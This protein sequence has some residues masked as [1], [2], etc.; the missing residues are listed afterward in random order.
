M[1]VWKSSG[2]WIIEYSSALTDQH[3]IGTGN[4]RTVIEYT[5]RK[6]WR[7]FRLVISIYNTSLDNVSEENYRQDFPPAEIHILGNL[8]ILTL[9]PMGSGYPLFPMGEGHMAPLV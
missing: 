2:Q 5:V 9:F 7:A 8:P 1:N 6:L 3:F 4:E